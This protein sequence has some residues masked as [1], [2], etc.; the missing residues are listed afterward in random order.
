L[1]KR[2]LTGRSARIRDF[3]KPGLRRGP[4]PRTGAPAYDVVRLTNHQALPDGPGAAGCGCPKREKAV[5]RGHN[6]FHKTRAER[7]SP[8]DKP[9]TFS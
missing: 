3:P 2:W 1:I 5:P 9:E 8:L 6:F 7:I 4:L